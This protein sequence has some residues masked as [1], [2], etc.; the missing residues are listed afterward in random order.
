MRFIIGVGIDKCLFIRI[1]SPFIQDHI[2]Q[3]NNAVGIHTAEADHRHR[4]C[5]DTGIHIFITCYREVFLYRR[6][7]HGELIMTTLEMIV[8]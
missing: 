4:P 8:T 3:C 2:C 6:L 5:H 7:G 1:F